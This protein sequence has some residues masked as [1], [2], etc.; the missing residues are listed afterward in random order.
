MENLVYGCSHVV[1]ADAAD[2]EAACKQE[3]LLFELNLMQA[4]RVGE[5][6]SAN[7]NV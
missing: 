4:N 3:D 7:V 6:G 5:Y 2:F 1:S